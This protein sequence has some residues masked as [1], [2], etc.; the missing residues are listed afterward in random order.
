M[1]NKGWVRGLIIAAIV[2]AFFGLIAIEYAFY[3]LK[4][5]RNVDESRDG[6]FPAFR[7]LDAKKWHRCK[8]Y[9]GALF[10]MPFRLV[11]IISQGIILSLMCK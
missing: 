1:E 8:F 4:R 2:Q 6:Q 7:R 11:F 9:P 10:S 3:R 5:M